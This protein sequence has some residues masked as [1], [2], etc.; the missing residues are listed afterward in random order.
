MIMN[1]LLSSVCIVLG[2]FDKLITFVGRTQALPFQS[3]PSEPKI[4]VLFTKLLVSDKLIPDRNNGV[5]LLL[6]GSGRLGCNPI[7]ASHRRSWKAISNL[8]FQP[9][10]F[11]FLQRG[12]S[13]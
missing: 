1:W 9:D 3:A 10:H 2:T 11:L 7:Q 5:L 12:A 13:S 4:G 6:P 8:E